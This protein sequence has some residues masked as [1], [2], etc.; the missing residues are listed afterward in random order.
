V[1][2]STPNSYCKSCYTFNMK[3]SNDI[4]GARLGDGSRCKVALF[5]IL[6]DDVAE[7]STCL[8]SGKQGGAICEACNGFGIEFIGR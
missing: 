8:G 5:G 4:C 1:K 2:K 6:E 7:C 3:Y